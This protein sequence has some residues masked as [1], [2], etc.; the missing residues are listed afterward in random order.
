MKIKTDEDADVNIT[1]L[2]DC[3]M[4]CIIFFMAIMS[5]Q[6]IFGVAIEFHSTADSKG[7]GK[8]TEE[9]KE[10]NI[11]VYVQSDMIEQGHRIVRDGILKVNGEDIALTSSNDPAKWEGERNYAFEYLQTKF[12]D[13][14]AQG[15]KKDVLMIQGDMTT[16]HWKV[17]SVIDR[18]K[19]EGIQGFSLGYPN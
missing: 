12:R 6:Y 13:L 11:T 17:M 18:G 3:L 4:Q 5:A 9:K 2:I 1:S 8:K 10:K 16:Y 15:C 14:I 7:A 19:A